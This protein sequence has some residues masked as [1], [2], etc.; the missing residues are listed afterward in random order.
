MIVGERPVQTPC[1]WCG[2]PVQQSPTGRLARYCRGRACRQ[3]AYEART[4]RR[5]LQADVDAGVIRPRPAE[6]IVERVVRDRHPRTPAGWETTLAALAGQF[7]DDTI[8]AW[9]TGRIRAALA[10]VEQQMAAAEARLS[11]LSPSAAAAVVRPAGHGLEAAIADRIAAAGGVLPTRLG[12]LSTDLAADINQLRR[13][14]IDL[15]R[16]GVITVRQRGAVTAV[17]ELAVNARCEISAR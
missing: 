13:T 4:A 3:R 8:G 16:R 14:L 6:R 9:H 7:A 2:E 17:D 11:A 15:E 5:R 10:A 1:E 12:R